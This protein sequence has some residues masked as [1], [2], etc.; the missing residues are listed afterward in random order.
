M[1]EWRGESAYWISFEE[2]LA[3]KV[4]LFVC[5]RPDGYDWS[6]CH[7]V[8]IAH[9]V[10]ER[11]INWAHVYVFDRPLSSRGREIIEHYAIHDVDPLMLSCLEHEMRKKYAHSDAIQSPVAQAPDPV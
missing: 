8:H 3:P 2:R 11:L 4:W 7:D 9:D 1:P 6:P 5:K 10:R